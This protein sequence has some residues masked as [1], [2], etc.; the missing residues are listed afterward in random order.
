MSKS[1]LSVVLDTNVF[2]PKHF[3]LLANSPLPRLCKA[4]RI[5]PVY[6]HVF[7]DEMWR[8]YGN[9]NRRVQ[10]V[11]RWIPFIVS[12][13]SRFCED[14]ITI[15]H[16]ELVEGHGRNTNIYMSSRV[17]GSVLVGLANAPLDGSWRAWHATQKERAEEDAKRVTQRRLFTEI[18]QE[19]AQ[20]LK[21]VGYSMRQH[22]G[23]V[24]FEEFL[25]AEIDGTGREFIKALVKCH[26]TGDVASRWSRD[27]AAYPYFT[28]FVTNMIYNGYYSAT[29]H[30]DGI[31]LNAQADLDLM[32]HLLHA[33]V[34]VSNETDYL[35]KAF[36][37]LWR[38]KGKVIFTSPEFVAFI[39]K[40]I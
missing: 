6:G 20:K 33:D 13:V 4:G 29:R 3:D 34:L 7:L 31:D 11:E 39:N 19:V 8:A 15:W 2:T 16:R 27:K 9:E 38:P 40:L 24:P 1:A 35:R 21:E 17:Q 28:T 37:D 32:S 22:G 5:V 26:N 23:P 12:T 25:Q 10:L 36:E 18:R 30:N 14:F